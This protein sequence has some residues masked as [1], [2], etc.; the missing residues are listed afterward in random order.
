MSAPSR[1]IAVAGAG[2]A[3]L[4]AALSFARRGFSVR[5]FERAGR[6]E[7]VG[8]GIQLSANATRILAR[9]GLLEAVEQTAVKPRSV[10][11]R[12]A[13]SGR[14][15]ASVPL[16]EAA[17]RR[18]GAPYLTVH[19]ADLHNVLAGAALAHPA[20]ALETGASVRG[21]TF[22]PGGVSLT[23]ERDGATGTVACD[24][25]VGADGVR[26]ALRGTGSLARPE[27]F[28]GYVAWRA[29]AAPH[30]CGDLVPADRV[31]AFL[32][33]RFHLVAY[34]LRRGEIVNLVAIGRM[35]APS[36]GMAGDAGAGAARGM[37]PPAVI[38][39]ATDEIDALA[40]GLDT[41]L[42]WPINEVD[43]D[44]PWVEPAG[45]ALIG[46]AA[47]AM[48]PYAAQGAVMAIE[49]AAALAAAV[50]ARPHD[51]A[52]ALRGYEATRRE[53]V[54]QV[55]RRGAFNRLVWHASGPVALGR[56]AVLALRR[57]ESLA[58]DLDWLYGY[59]AEAV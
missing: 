43:A 44:A 17:T 56:D 18:W 19:R 22:G 9:L 26:S 33:P 30:A 34:P 14:V 1:Q 52:G 27:R 57:P 25:A 8:A 48:G 13:G 5:I 46:D 20:I 53:R 36:G 38:S 49:D 55:A 4:A 41:W 6:L 39:G 2:I 31:S 47:H 7:E 54:R 21:A 59:D 58:A 51:L 42:P 35:P 40:A 10:E 3:G 24:L 45:L 23:V 15:I 11:L 28:S 29:T 12:R 16:G 50:A 32:H 37:L